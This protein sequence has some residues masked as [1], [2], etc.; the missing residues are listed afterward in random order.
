MQPNATATATATG[1]T[2]GETVNATVHSNSIDVGQV[3]AAPDGS[4]HLMFTVPADLA[5]GTH[6]LVLVGQTSGSHDRGG[7]HR[8][9]P[10]RATGWP[11][12]TA[13]VLPF[14]GAGLFGSAES[15]HLATPIVGI[16]ATSDGGGYWLAAADGGVFAYGDAAFYG[17]MGG[18]QLNSPIVGMAATSDGGGYWLVAADGGVFAF[19]DAAFHGS[20]GDTRLNAPVVGIA[21]SPDGLGYWLVA[22]DGGVFAFGDA[23]IPRV[24]GRTRGSMPPSSA[25][26]RVQPAAIGWPRPTGASS[27][28]MP[29]STGRW[30]GRA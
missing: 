13:R 30:A 12:R 1:F 24:D 6:D 21:A 23:G 28:S 7:L 17:S 16:A 11:Q 25:L 15:I 20:M 9:S 3:V 18:R 26:R 19:G 8:D 29:R 27:P 5:A 14:G 4:V 10:A 2:P 22:A